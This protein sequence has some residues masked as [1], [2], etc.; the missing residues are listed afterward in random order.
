VLNDVACVC[1]HVDECWCVR[2]RGVSILA[3]TKSVFV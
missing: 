2:V 3:H 1:M